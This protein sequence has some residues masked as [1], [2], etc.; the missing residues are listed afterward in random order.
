M[1]FQEIQQKITNLYADN[2]ASV[3][4]YLSC[5]RAIDEMED[6][7][8][9]YVRPARA[10]FLSSFT[11]QGLA[12]VC[13]AKAVFHNLSLHCFTAPYNQFTQSVL[14][15]ESDLYASNPQLIYLLI[16]APDILDEKHLE[17]VVAMLTERTSAHMILFNFATSPAT[18]KDR[19]DVLNRHVEML[20]KDNARITVFD[21]AGFLDR[22]GR[23]TCW[24]TKYAQMG[25]LRIAPNAFP[26]LAEVLLSY[27]VGVAGNTKKC[28][29]LDLDNTL[30]QGIV[31][32]DGIDGIVPDV[33]LQNYLRERFEKGTILAINSKNN[34]DDALQVFERRSDM[35]LKKDHVAAWRINW[36]SKEKNM[37]ELAQELNLGT[38]SFVFI[39]DDPFQRELIGVAFPEIAVMP[40]ERIFD[41]AGFFSFSVTEEDRRRGAMYTEE[42]MRNELRHALRTEEDF[43]KELNLRVAIQDVLPATI[44]RTSQLTQKT[45]QFNLT[46]R[47]Y[48]EDDIK[49][50][51]AQGWHVWTVAVSDRFGDYGIVGVIMVEPKENQWRIDTFLLS[52][53]VLGRRVEHEVVRH[54]VKIAKE[55]RIAAIVAEYIPTPKNGQTKNFWDG[56]AFAFQSEKDN[57]KQYRY[58]FTS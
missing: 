4:A 27:A 45:N 1:K 21:I 9:L 18:T 26:A 5:A 49:R 8:P 34:G 38:D 19:A 10:A 56:M 35:V 37:H 20:Y 42:R 16:D 51:A 29:V 55:Q 25:D 40:P 32:E 47:R 57:A 39:D 13:R 58:E 28:A 52:C 12:D 15:A 48:S 31:G 36:E 22:V 11:I 3:A 30:W 46:T 53:R 50:L 43:L 14:S 33:K 7:M 23:D 2:D 41:Y 6:K 24:Y 17:D 54:L 44:A